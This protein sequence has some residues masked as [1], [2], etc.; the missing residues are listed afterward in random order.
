MTDATNVERAVWVDAPHR[1]LVRDVEPVS[2]GRGE[3]LVRIAYAGI[4]G[5]DRELLAGTRPSPYVRY[6]VIPGHEW[7]GTVASVGEGADPELV[8]TKVVGQGIRPCGT[9]AACR[10]GDGN[11]CEGPYAE[12]GFT[13]PGAFSDR[14]LL[15]ANLLHVLPD[16][17]DL[18]AAAC[19]EPAAC[20][21]AAC[22]QADARPGG[23]AAVVGGGM[24]GLLA[25]QFLR[26][27]GAADILVVEPES[28]RRE[29]A[30]LCGASGLVNPDDA[31]PYSGTFDVVVEA[32]GAGDAAARA[33]SLARRG[34][35]VVLTGIPGGGEPVLDPA[36]LVTKALTVHTT[37]GA[38]PRAWTHAVRAFATGAIDPGCLV[39]HE[40][41][42]D[43]AELAFDLLGSGG[44]AALKVLLVP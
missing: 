39:T 43:E 9:C 33:V 13:E 3:A 7:S 5:S 18:R 32:A 36:V 37:F 12:T 29:V 19:L 4:C 44:A 10:R 20:V 23:R 31:E 14:L 24:L 42:L 22:L 41:G 26:A 1:L 8:G 16:D 25:V 27:A 11:L 21:A 17:A 28:G 2:P 34:G 40:V 38:P 6:P 15:P 30:L 35:R